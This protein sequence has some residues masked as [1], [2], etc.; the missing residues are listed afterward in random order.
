MRRRGF[1]LI[2]LLVVIG[3][4]GVLVALLLPAVQAA[5]ESGRRTICLA[6]LHQLAVAAEMYHDALGCYPPGRVP[7]FDPRVITPNYPCDMPFVDRGP[8]VLLLPQL[9]EQQA[10]DAF[11]QSVAAGTPENY[12]TL[13]RIIPAYRCPSDNGK[14]TRQVKESALG[15][16]PPNT[17]DAFMLGRNSYVGNFGTLNVWAIP[18]SGNNCR[19]FP[20]TVAQ[21]D[22]VFNDVH[23]LKRRD[24]SDGLSKTLLFTERR[25]AALDNNL[26]AGAPE[27]EEAWWFSGNIGDSLAVGAIPPN[28]GG[29]V[30]GGSANR[31]S[32]T[33]SSG[34]PG[35]VAIVLADGAARFVADSIDSWADGGDIGPA[36]AAVGPGGAWTNLPARGIWQAL[37]TR[38]GNEANGNDF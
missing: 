8:L 25:T 9:E 16:I 15:L 20:Q 24:L 5:R 6:R 18:S 3:I 38:A 1:T 28:F 37:W 11:N 32:S 14:E 10:F 21:V 36:G 2:E 30:A 13:R 17:P 33:A 31:R 4:L 12:T 23:P 26:D 7:M 27:A 19:A 29:A 22:G 34:H 35:G